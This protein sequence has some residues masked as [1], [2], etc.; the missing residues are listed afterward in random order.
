VR[1]AHFLTINFCDR[2]HAADLYFSVFSCV[3]YTRSTLV[4]VQKLE[5]HAALL[6]TIVPCFTAYTAFLADVK[7]IF[8]TSADMA[9]VFSIFLPFLENKCRG[10]SCHVNTYTRKKR[11]KSTL[12]ESWI[13]AA[14][15]LFLSAMRL[16]ATLV[17]RA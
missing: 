12:C 8:S 3:F 16:H 15:I 2:A 13:E 10:K 4:Q 11:Q 1:Y 17:N 14:N 6:T 5:L 7:K 9:L